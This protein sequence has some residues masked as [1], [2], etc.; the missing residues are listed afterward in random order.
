MK[1]TSMFCCESP[2]ATVAHDGRPEAAGAI[3]VLDAEV[4][5]EEQAAKKRPAARQ[6]AI[7]RT[8]LIMTS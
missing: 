3:V 6:L 8:L 1:S 5:P 7:A 2:A 4:T